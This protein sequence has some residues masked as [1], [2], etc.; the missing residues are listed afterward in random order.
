MLH[1]DTARWNQT[2][3]D[4]RQAAL[5]AAHPRTRERFQALYEVATQ[6]WSAF[7]WSKQTERRHSTILEW[8]RTYNEAGPD[9]L[10]FVH[11]GGRTPLL[12]R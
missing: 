10:A 11:T 1:V 6:V 2:P 7:G 12:L 3:E 8:I 9:A 4:L 5:H